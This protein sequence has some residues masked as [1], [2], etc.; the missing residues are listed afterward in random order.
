MIALQQVFTLLALIWAAW[1]DWHEGLIDDRVSI[2]II[3]CSTTVMH[4]LYGITI[5]LGLL[6]LAKHSKRMGEGDP[7]ILGS[8]SGV[9]STEEF[10]QICILTTMLM[11]MTQVTSQRARLGPYI[12]LATGAVFCMHLK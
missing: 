2:I 11:L 3:L 8:L 4:A 7:L 10:S 9:L 1:T 5:S 12:M 6:A